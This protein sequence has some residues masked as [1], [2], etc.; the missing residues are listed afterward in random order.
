VQAKEE[1]FYQ[2]HA[3]TVDDFVRVFHAFADHN[4]LLLPAHARLALGEERLLTILL[5]GGRTLLRGRCRATELVSD[6]QNAAVRVELLA[7]DGPSRSLHQRLLEAG[8]TDHGAGA[9]PLQLLR[10]LF[11]TVTADEGPDPARDFSDAPTRVAPSS[12]ELAVL[13]PRP[14]TSRSSG[15]D[16][17]TTISMTARSG[18]EEPTRAAPSIARALAAQD[19]ATV[20]ALLR[21]DPKLASGPPTPPPAPA[22][23]RRPGTEENRELRWILLTLALCLASFG[24]GYWA[25]GASVAGR[26]AITHPA[27]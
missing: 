11:A 12:A 7:L 21:A 13:I 17:A 5:D 15:I 10:G 18:G 26:A 23:A 4:G 1:I 6:E 16:E 25:R 8:A 9:P 20:L 24:L 3:G 22:V 14:V 2:A 27:D 19:A